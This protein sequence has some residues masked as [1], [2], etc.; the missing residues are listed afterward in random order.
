[1]K[2]LQLKWFLL[3]IALFASIPFAN[4]TIIDNGSFTTDTST[5]LDWLDVTQTLN[6]SYDEVYIELSEG[7]SFEEWRYANIDELYG[8]SSNYLGFTVSSSVDDYY[9]FD[10]NRLKDLVKLLG[11]TLDAGFLLEH[12]YTYE[13]QPNYKVGYD[14]NFT[15]GWILESNAIGTPKV[16]EGRVMNNESAGDYL[17]AQQGYYFPTSYSNIQRGSYLVRDTMSIPTPSTILLLL[18][19]MFGFLVFAPKARSRGA[20][21]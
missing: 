2:H 3:I 8:L 4:A 19:G 16:I 5:K 7:G 18:I 13:Q 9:Y 15:Q 10:D 21:W 20:A 17:G 11:N 12:G 6:F 14:L 1:M